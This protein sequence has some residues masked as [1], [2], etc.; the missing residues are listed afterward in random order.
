MKISSGFLI[1]S[2]DLY[3]LCHA[4]QVNVQPSLDDGHWTISKGGVEEGETLLDAAIR[5]LKEETDID[6]TEFITEDVKEINKYSS[7]KRTAHV[8]FI[9]DETGK[10][11]KT[12]LK[13]NSLVTHLGI[14]EM[15]DYFWATKEQAKT[16]VFQSQKHLFEIEGV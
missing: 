1:K 12:Q 3:L 5:E 16:M 2:K 10:L 6:I 7:N 9:N 13:C 11:L 15:D 14:Y 8:F 4:T